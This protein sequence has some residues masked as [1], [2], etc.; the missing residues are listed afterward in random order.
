MSMV[1]NATVFNFEPPPVNHGFVPVE[2]DPHEIYVSPSNALFHNNNS[3]SGIGDIRIRNK[4]VAWQSDDEKSTIA[5][6]LDLRLP[7]GDAYNFTGSGT[8]GIRP[9]VI[10]S[11]SGQL[12]PHGGAGF[13]G[14]GTSVLAGDVTQQPVV[15]DHLPDVISYY[16]GA[17][18]YLTKLR[19]LGASADFIGN[20]LIGA[21]R[22]KATT[23][24]DYGGNTHPD[25]QS[26]TATVNEAA[27]SLGG[28]I[29]VKRFLIVGNVLIR[30]NDA[31]LHFK[32]SPLAGVSYTF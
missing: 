1:S 29:R 18:Y 13:E 31:G 24:T 28:K 2:G 27:V 21:P 4:F 32:P 8:W 11:R 12:S 3:S 17:D 20:S 22:V 6:G 30:L 7:T 10:Y 23:T 15:K 19:W 9:F 16:G 26:S 25:I 14:N 5:V